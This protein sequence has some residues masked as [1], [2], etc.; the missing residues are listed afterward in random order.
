MNYYQ[1]GKGTYDNRL[2]SIN[3]QYGLQT[4]MYN[5]MQPRYN[6]QT[7][8]PY[9][10]QIPMMN[11]QPNIGSVVI[12]V[13]GIEEVKAY[14]TDFSGNITYFNDIT[15]GK[16]YTKQLNLEGISEI[17]S[18]SLDNS[19]IDNPSAMQVNK[20]QYDLLAKR[21]NEIE[22]EISKINKMLGGF[23]NESNAN[24]SNV[25]AETN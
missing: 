22:K 1:F 6:Q 21:I 14:P 13:G 20:Q 15:N 10:N 25:S 9:N 8:Q 3:Q 18:Y 19:P 24:V 16:I 5:Q 17:K 4:P 11:N 2:N 7:Q 12:P 23:N